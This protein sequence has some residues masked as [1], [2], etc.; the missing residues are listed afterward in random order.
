MRQ[1]RGDKCTV[2]IIP[3]SIGLHEPFTQ[4]ICHLKQ[5]FAVGYRGIVLMHSLVPC[6][7]KDVQNV[8]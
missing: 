5:T 3:V 7:S 8:S 6:F 2:L 1:H 4:T